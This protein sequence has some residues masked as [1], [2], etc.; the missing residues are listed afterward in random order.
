M[1]ECICGNPNCTTPRGTCHCGCGDAAPIARRADNRTGVMRG[2]PHRYIKGHSV[3]PPRGPVTPERVM[4]QVVK[5]EGCWEWSG[6]FTKDGY[7][8]IWDPDAKTHVRV[9]RVLT[10]WLAPI[11]KGMVPDHLC[12]NRGCVNPHHAD[13]VT[14]EENTRRGWRDGGHP[15]PTHCP[16]GHEYT[17]ENT[18]VTRGRHSCRM[19]HRASQAK[20]NARNR[21]VRR[22]N[23]G[24]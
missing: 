13:I 9:F 14:P 18:R 15:R 7:A 17:P 16:R 24:R 2:Q 3:A 1:A 12:R 21:E 19:C 6:G 23:S 8:R 10:N 11:P 20:I 4:A 22:G 5:T